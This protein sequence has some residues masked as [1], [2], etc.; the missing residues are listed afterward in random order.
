MDIDKISLTNKVSFGKKGLKYFIGYKDK[1]T[2]KQFYETK[3]LSFLIK[4][5]SLFYCIKR[6]IVLTKDWIVNHK[7]YLKLKSS[8][9]K[10][11]SI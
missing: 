3:Y 5:D 2:F 1:W 8:L 6:A 4:D 9:M 11:K 10:V 7:K